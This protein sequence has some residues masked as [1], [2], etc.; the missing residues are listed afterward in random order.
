M[1][2][3]K[4]IQ[5]ID[6]KIVLL[7]FTTNEVFM[8]KYYKKLELDKILELLANETVSDFWK[9]KALKIAVFTINETDLFL[10]FLS[11]LK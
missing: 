5:K 4:R 6:D 10:I 2:I 8:N 9:E 3:L 7:R 1:K 11:P